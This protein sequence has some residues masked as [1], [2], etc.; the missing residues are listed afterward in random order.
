MT[1]RYTHTFT[2]HERA[3]AEKLGVLFGTEWPEK[4]R[5]KLLS[6]PN[7]S[8]MQKRPA[9]SRQRAIAIQ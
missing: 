1:E 9:E 7:L 3:A 4:E 6:F 8:Q 5:G 2:Q